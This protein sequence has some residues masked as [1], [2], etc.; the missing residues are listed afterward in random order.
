V[1]F[2]KRNIETT[3]LSN[4]LNYKKFGLFRV[5]SNIRDISYKLELSKKIRI[6]LI[7]YISLLKL[8]DLN[9]L[10][11]LILKLHLNT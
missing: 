6:Y 4:K 5:K 11:E 3:R 8:V 9:T 10:K 1:Y 7:F 2:L